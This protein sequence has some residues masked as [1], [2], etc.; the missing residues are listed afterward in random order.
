MVNLPYP[1][2]KFCVRTGI[3]SCVA[4]VSTIKHNR[5]PGYTTAGDIFPSGLNVLVAVDP[6]YA[7]PETEPLSFFIRPFE[8]PIP[9]EQGP[10]PVSDVLL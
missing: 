4:L 3:S 10:L 7:N 8:A 1:R 6:N 2:G 9:D 5:T